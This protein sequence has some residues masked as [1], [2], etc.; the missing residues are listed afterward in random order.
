MQTAGFM[1]LLIEAAGIMALSDKYGLGMSDPFETFLA[2][3]SSEDVWR[4]LCHLHMARFG[5]MLASM[6]RLFNI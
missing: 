4:C 3:A 2:R 1:I 5:L 6:G